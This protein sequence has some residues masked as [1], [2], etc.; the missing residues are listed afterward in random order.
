MSPRVQGLRTMQSQAT[1]HWEGELPDGEDQLQRASS[2]NRLQSITVRNNCCHRP[3][4]G[5]GE[6]SRGRHKGGW[7][8][9]SWGSSTNAH[10]NEHLGWGDLAGHWRKDMF[11]TNTC[12]LWYTPSQLS[13]TLPCESWIVFLGSEL[14]TSFVDFVLASLTLDSGIMLWF[15]ELWTVCCRLGVCGY[16]DCSLYLMGQLGLSSWNQGVWSEGQLQA[17]V[18]LHW[19]YWSVIW[20]CVTYAI[21]RLYLTS[22]F[23]TWL[24]SEHDVKNKKKGP[25][26]SL[27]ISSWTVKAFLTTSE[28]WT[29]WV[30]AAVLLRHPWWQLCPKA[31]VEEVVLFNLLIFKEQIFAW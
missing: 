1:R 10:H 27:D 19:Y 13:W 24:W 12:L 28:S 8:G 7:W 5:C 22:T 4:L 6:W 29:K 3:I 15:L 23:S 17:E 16:C 26:E 2:D 11:V 31:N 20:H 9:C 25:A 18:K 14:W 21:N 30:S